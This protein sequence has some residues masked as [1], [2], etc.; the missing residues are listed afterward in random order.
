MP[1]IWFDNSLKLWKKAER[2]YAQVLKDRYWDNLVDLE[3]APDKTFKDWDI[4]IKV[5]EDWEVHVK[6]YEIKSDTKSQ[7]T[8]NFVVEFYS[9][10]KPSWIARTK[11]DYWCHYTLPSKYYEDGGWREQNTEE[12]KKKLKEK[13][14]YVVN[15][16]DK[17][18]TRMFR[19]PCR[20]LPNFFYKIDTDIKW[21]EMEDEEFLINQPASC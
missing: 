18:A 7:E 11:A 19:I 1:D 12:L 9:R 6:T 14:W 10:G 3:F 4:R 5:L 21:G 2:R 20:E 17:K 13:K 8:W 16:W 15:W